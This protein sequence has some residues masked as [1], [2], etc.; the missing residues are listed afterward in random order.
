MAIMLTEYAYAAIKS[1]DGLTASDNLISI[2]LHCRKLLEL[3]FRT[4][5]GKAEARA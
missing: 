5:T 3:V 2:L 1:G 4:S